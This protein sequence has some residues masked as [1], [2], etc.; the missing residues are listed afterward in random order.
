M[1]PAADT[2]EDSIRERAYHIWEANGRPAGRDEEFWFRACATIVADERPAAASP[3]K[4]SRP[5]AKG[6]GRVVTR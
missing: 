1:K 5:R 2:M 4:R 6:N 3:R